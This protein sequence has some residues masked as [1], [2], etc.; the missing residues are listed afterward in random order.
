MAVITIGFFDGVHLGHRSLIENLV[1]SAREHSEPSIVTTFWPH[2]RMVLQKDARGLRL[3]ST[4]QEKERR[5]KVLGVDRIEVLPFTRQFASLTAEQYL[6]EI[7]NTKN[8]GSKLVLGYDNR[9]GSDQLSP[10]QTVKLA[11]S[12]GIE[13]VLCE[14]YGDI[15]STKIRKALLEGRVEFANECLGYGYSLRGVVVGGKQLGRT[16]GYPTANMQRYDPLKLVPAAGAYLTRVRVLGREFYGMTNVGTVIET[17]IFDFDED[18]YGLDIEL[19]FEAFI[20]E[21]MKFSSVGE[22]KKQLEKDEMS[23]KKHIFGI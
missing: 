7:L 22:L 8:A 16:I 11:S 14:A 13:A 21:E 12:M 6:R 23:A 3:L 4:M 10:Q 2:P 1:Q 20:R 18:I 15:S 17:H 9:I 5:L 19:T